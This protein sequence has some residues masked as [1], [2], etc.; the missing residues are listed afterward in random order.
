[1]CDCNDSP[2]RVGQ[3]RLSRAC[4]RWCA[5]AAGHREAHRPRRGTSALLLCAIATIL[6]VLVSSSRRRID[7]LTIV[8]HAGKARTM[9]P[10]APAQ[11]GT[12]PHRRSWRP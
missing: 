9:V 5:V 11:H 8:S 4:H 2:Q 10:V 3:H 6:L 12:L 1:M 7:S